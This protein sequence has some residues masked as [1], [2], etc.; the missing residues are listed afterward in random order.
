MRPE[1]AVRLPWAPKVPD[2]S[3]SDAPR[4]P[5]SAKRHTALAA[6]VTRRKA[7]GHE[8]HPR[9]P[10]ASVPK[11]WWRLLESIRPELCEPGRRLGG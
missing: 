9:R 7:G 2:P 5:G 11:G 10:P 1:G 8:G 4:S 6:G 3:S